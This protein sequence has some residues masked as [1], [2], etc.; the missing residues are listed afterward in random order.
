[1]YEFICKFPEVS[2]LRDVL[3]YQ[4]VGVL[5]RAFLPRGVAVGEVNRRFQGLRYRPVPAELDP[6]VRGYRQDILPVWP[7][8]PDDSLR[9][10]LR[11]LNIRQ[12]FHY[13]VV[14][15][16]LAQGQNR[17]LLAFPKYQ[18]HLP[19]TE[20]LPVRFART[21]VD[22]NPVRDVGRF[23]RPIALLVTPVL[24]PVAA[25]LLQFPAL[26]CADHLIYPLVRQPD[27]VLQQIPGYLLRRPLL[28]QQ[29]P[30][31]L[32]QHRCRC[33][34]VPHCPLTPV[35]RPL[36]RYRP[37]ILPLAVAVP[38]DFSAYC[39]LVDTY[40]PSNGRLC[41]S[42]LY[43]QIDCV[44]LLPGQLVIHCNTKLIDPRGTSVPLS[45]FCVATCSCP[46]HLASGREVQQSVARGPLTVALRC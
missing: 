37:P 7:Q 46:T 13:K 39:A 24:H 8:Q 6:V 23:R 45:C 19:V 15:A 1:M 33:R 9:H 5:Y 32:M 3:P 4:L 25:V 26:V 21:I 34:P 44:S 29:Q 38:A 10:F 35:Q 17:A 40:L 2:P 36:V 41:P 42:L 12:P 22:A 11:V 14:P 30:P 20:P 31:R 16:P 18:V 28:R 43:S 27:T